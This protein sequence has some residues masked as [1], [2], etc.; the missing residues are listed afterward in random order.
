M[1][2][3]ERPLSLVPF[4]YLLVSRIRSP[5][6]LAYLA[7][8]SWVPAWW[9][10]VR[11]GEMGPFEALIHFAA[12]YVAFISCYEMGYLT[13][14]SWDAR[15][16]SDGRQRIA[17]R[18]TPAYAAIFVAIRV[19]AWLAV[20]IGTGWIGQ[21]AWLFGY[22]ALAAVFTLH[23]AIQAPG[24]RIATFLQL[25]LLRFLLPIVGGLQTSTYLIAL[26]VAFL[27]YSTFRLLSYLDS[28]DLLRMSGRK[29]GRFLLSFVAIEAPLAL[30]LC[31]LV[32]SSVIAEMLVYYCLLYAVIALRDV[33]SAAAATD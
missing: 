18:V 5:L 31:L 8:S 21:P 32:R 23:N 19:S 29:S 27:F 14:D 13:N 3:L 7:G 9:L 26:S 28:K 1:S 25:S 15:R 17:F 6:E 11:L 10:L 22:L 33:S 4:G 30:Y 16:S 24:L 20:G 2:R 12:G